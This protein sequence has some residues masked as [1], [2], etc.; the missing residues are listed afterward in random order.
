MI[1]STINT[2]VQASRATVSRLFSLYAAIMA[3]IN[4]AS[5]DQ[6]FAV[7]DRMAGNVMAARQA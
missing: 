4:P 3:T 2:A 7:E 6:I 5:A 1:R